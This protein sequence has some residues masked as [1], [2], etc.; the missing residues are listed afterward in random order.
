MAADRLN[1]AAWNDP[2]QALAQCG[3]DNTSVQSGRRACFV[4][5]WIEPPKP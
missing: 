2:K 4:P 1:L 3:K 5:L